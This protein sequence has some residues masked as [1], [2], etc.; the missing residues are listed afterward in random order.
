VVGKESY[1]NSKGK[2]KTRSVYGDVYAKVYE[3]RKSS[4][5][6]LSGSYKVLDV[7][8]GKI[9][10]QDRFNESYTWE[11]KWITF[12]GDERALRSFSGRDYDS[13]E[14]N[15]PTNSEMGDELVDILTK[16]MAFKIKN[17]LN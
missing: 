14:L 11:N 17:L 5:A 4:K 8:T 3:H 1:V 13:N 7:K 6:M 10:S 12:T 15:P 2:T 9:L 16:K